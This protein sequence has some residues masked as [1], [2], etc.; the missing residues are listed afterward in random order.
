M[1]SLTV[2]ENDKLHTCDPV[3]MKSY[4]AS[5]CILKKRMQRSA[6]PPPEASI[7]C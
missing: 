1:I 2:R 7:L 6:V 3:S 4:Y 5:V